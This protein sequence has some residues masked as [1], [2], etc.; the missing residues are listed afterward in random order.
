MPYENLFWLH[1]KKS[2]G[3]T[4]R[5]L[6]QPHYTE[7]D[8]SGWPRNFLQ[9]D[10]VEYNDILNNYRVVLGE[11]QFR[12]AL[13]ARRYLYPDSW[14][15]L[16]SFAFSR[17]PVDRCLSMFYYLFPRRTGI[18][19]SLATLYRGYVDTRKL[20]FSTSYAF[21]VFLDFAQRARS[22]ESVYRPLG[23]HFTTHTA[24]MWED[25]TDLDGSLLLKQVFRL[26]HL[27]E[28][29]NT[30][31]ECCGINQRVERPG[32]PLNINRRRGSYT[33]NPAQRGK[34]ER[35][36]SRDFDLYENAWH[37]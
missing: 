17:E 32:Q 19:G 28:G 22:S 11:L 29:I 1:I 21:D 7:V 14:D 9:S 33:P 27:V 8:R 16:Y 6:L 23:L 20:M 36:Y 3:V 34:I 4:T 25:V 12:R 24:P 5:S 15:K 26:E 35:I 37:S 30:A 31:F 13:F 2:A 10:P 18:L